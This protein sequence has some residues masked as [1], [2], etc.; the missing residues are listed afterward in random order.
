MNQKQP[1]RSEPDDARTPSEAERARETQEILD[2]ADD[3]DDRA[4]VRDSLADLRDEAA[5]LEAFL[6]D[7]DGGAAGLKA[8]RFAVLDRE[9]SKVDRVAAAG[10]RTR[11]ARP[12]DDDDDAPTP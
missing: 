11:L 5:S 1:S 12:R 2:A 3:R 6:G 9:D 10:D 4:S 7:T 8:R